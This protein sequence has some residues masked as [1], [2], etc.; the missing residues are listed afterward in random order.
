LTAPAPGTI[1]TRLES[2][3]ISLNASVRIWERVLGILGGG[4]VTHGL[5]GSLSRAENSQLER[6]PDADSVESLLRSDETTSG[7]SSTP[8]AHLSAQH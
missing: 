1:G 2:L 6:R 3:L 7:K 4:V 5:V 8:V